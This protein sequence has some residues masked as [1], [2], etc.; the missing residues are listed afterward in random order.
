MNDPSSSPE[1]V[2]ELLGRFLEELERTEDREALLR[3]WSGMFPQHAQEFE[4]AVRFRPFSNQAAYT[5]EPPPD[6]LPDFRIIRRIGAGGMG[7]VYEAEQ[8]SLKRHVAVKVRRGRASAGT[9]ERFFRE[10]RVLAR[11]HQTH[12]VPIHTSGQAGPWQ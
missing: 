1:S 10:Q 4:D 5:P 12:I 3:K 9:K 8:V 2:D 6:A 11:L 7:V